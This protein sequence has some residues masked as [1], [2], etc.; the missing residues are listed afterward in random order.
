MLKIII[1]L[2]GSS[3]I[4]Q[5]AGFPY[6]K[7]LIEIKGKPMI[8]WVIESTKS[9]VMPNQIVF[10]IKEEDCNVYHLDNTLKL[11]DSNCEI[12]KIK[13]NTKG[14]LC[15]VLMAVDKIGNE[16][17]ILILNSDQI[18]E[19]DLSEINNYWIKKQSDVGVVTFKSVH[20]RWSYALSEEEKIIQT[21]EK[22]PISNQAIAGYYYFNSAELFFDCAF[23]TIIN[24]VQTDGMFFIS[25]V[26]NEFILRNKKVN[27]YQL[28][29]KKY[30]SF[31]SPKL[32]NEFETNYK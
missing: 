4:F 16:D 3:E 23:Q 28:D 19:K 8:E 9:L 20:P 15:S 10:I 21:A 12:V 27:F 24:D 29:I 5:K 17:S 11:L 26:I 22:N 14:G 25:P 18:I 13:N 6:P 1:P 31:Y 2:A 7:P 30:H 32:I